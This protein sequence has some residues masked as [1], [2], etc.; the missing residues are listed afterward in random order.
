M[1]CTNVTCAS[2]Q[3][4]WRTTAHVA[5]PPQSSTVQSTRVCVYGCIN[6]IHSSRTTRSMQ[7][8][9]IF[10]NFY[11]DLWM[12]LAMTSVCSLRIEHLLSTA[13]SHPVGTAGS[14]NPSQTE[15]TGLLLCF[16]A[17]A[18][19]ERAGREKRWNHTCTATCR[20]SVV[21]C[22]GTATEHT[23]MSRLTCQKLVKSWALHFWD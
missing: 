23:K 17:A 18:S 22:C 2:P 5:G 4:S 20:F 11:C 12:L 8:M 7:W 15:E 6:T 16:D 1:Q 9:M 10:K 19:S 3:T 14:W 13:R 21:W